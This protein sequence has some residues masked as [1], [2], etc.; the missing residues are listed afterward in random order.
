MRMPTIAPDV[1][2]AARDGR[3]EALDVILRALEPPVYALA[4]RMLRHREDARDACQEIL[5]TIV[6]HLG[7]FRGEA[8]FGTWAFQIA[9]NHLLRARAR[10]VAVSFEALAEKLGVGTALAGAETL[11]PED[12]A[13]AREIG[14]SCTEGMLLALDPDQRL[15]YLLDLMF[16]LTSDEA[17]EVLG[18]TPATFRKRL[19][20]ARDAL[21]GHAGSVCGRVNEAAPCRCTRQAVAMRKTGY[22]IPAPNAASRVFNGLVRLGDVASLFRALPAEAAPAAILGA[23]RAVLEG[24]AGGHA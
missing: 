16:G 8:A 6:T 2:R 24:R 13:A 21:H 15:A 14:L 12:H 1:L 20:R 18:I 10:P 22:P 7:G 9:R 5:L 17:A 19:S 4:L 11:T 23:I 3:F